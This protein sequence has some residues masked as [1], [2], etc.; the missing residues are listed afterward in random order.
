MQEQTSPP[1]RAPLLVAEDD[2]DL[3]DIL[4]DILS[5]EGYAV[6]PASSQAEALTCIDKATFALIL[7]D[8]F[9]KPFND[10]LASA[11]L[12]QLHAFPTPV[13]VVTAWALDQRAVE[14]ANLACV[15]P[16]PFDFQDLLGCITTTVDLR[17]SPDQERRAEIVRRYLAALDAQDWD[18]LLAL[19]APDVVF[20]RPS[21]PLGPAPRTLTGVAE[22]RTQREETV[23]RFP[24]IQ[25]EAIR[26]FPQTHGLAARY[27]VRIPMHEG[28][29][30]TFGAALVFQFAGERISTIG[31][32]ASSERLAA[33]MAARPKAQG[34][35]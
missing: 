14:E 26:V 35:S 32:R 15:I 25:H 18:T 6:T 9:E 33:V 1:E 23:R 20:T 17:L 30:E 28:Q 24:G 27:V 8:L 10:P 34:A 7:T 22:L 19:C 13:A 12:L 3:R 21:M 29:D 5:E 4:R 31:A 11:R 16:K 2:P